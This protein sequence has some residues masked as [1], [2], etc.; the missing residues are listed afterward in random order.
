MKRTHETTRSSETETMTHKKA[1]EKYQ[2]KLYFFEYVEEEV[3]LNNEDDYD[4]ED[5]AQ[6]LFHHVW[7]WIHNRR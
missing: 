4:R 1:M 3:E 5:P 7:Q 2:G 6:A